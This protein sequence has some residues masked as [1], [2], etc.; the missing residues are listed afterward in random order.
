MP[1]HFIGSREGIIVPGIKKSAG[2]LA[3]PPYWRPRVRPTRQRG[4]PAP[5]SL[6]PGQPSAFF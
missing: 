6:P 4:P 1:D 3:K 2:R 5:A